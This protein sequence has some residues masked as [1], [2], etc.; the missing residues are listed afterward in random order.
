MAGSG[1]GTAQSTDCLR[2]LL[3]AFGVLPPR[4][5]HLAAIERHLARML[6]RH[7]KYAMLLG[8]YARWYVLPRARGRAAR[9]AST[10]GRARWAYTRI[11]TAVAL[12]EHLASLD[13][14]LSEATQL[15]VDRWLAAG[16]STRYEVRDFLVWT[17]RRGHSNDL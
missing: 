15:E 17:A 2:G 7:P 10:R 4:D 5:E 12:L 6:T 13:L 16:P 11:E 1:R 9:S 14:T 3:V 8:P